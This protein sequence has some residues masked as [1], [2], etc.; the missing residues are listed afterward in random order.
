MDYRLTI[1]VMHCFDDRYTAPAAVAF[2][3]MLEHGAKDCFFALYVVHSDITPEHQNML[4]KVVAR[5]PNASLDFIVP[6]DRIDEDGAEVKNVAHYSKEMFFK[7]TAAEEFPQYDR[8]MIT[9]VDVLYADD[10]SKIYEQY[11]QDENYVIGHNGHRFAPIAWIDRYT[12]TSY[13]K[14]FTESERQALSSGVGAGYLIF[15]LKAMRRDGIVRKFKD[16]LK[17]NI[18]R[19]RQPEQDVINLVCAGNIG[20][21]PLRAMVC[22]YLWRVL[23]ED[24]KPAWK[25]AMEH[26]VQLHFPGPDKPWVDVAAIKSDLW[27]GYLVRT[28]FFYEVAQKFSL[29]PRKSTYSFFGKVPFLEIWSRG[30]VTKVRLGRFF[31]LRKAIPFWRKKD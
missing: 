7:L 24:E 31:N 6:K 21:L 25:E 5:F 8:L 26:P 18:G 12:D 3:S 10:I 17:E 15:N 11:L 1:P 20:Y 22:T 23:E 2:L 16:Y 13:S 4:Q 30:A 28:P 9:D 14:T 27:W 29:V 19:I